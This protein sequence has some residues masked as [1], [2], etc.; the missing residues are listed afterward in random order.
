VGTLAVPPDREAGFELEHRTVDD[1]SLKQEETGFR[2]YLL[3][4]RAELTGDLIRDAA[5]APDQGQ[6][7]GG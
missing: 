3:K 2:T 7:T 5:A 1:A 4:S 6:G